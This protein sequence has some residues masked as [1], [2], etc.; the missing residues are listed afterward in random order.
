MIGCRADAPLSK[1]RLARL[2]VRATFKGLTIALLASTPA[3]ADGGDGGNGTGGAGGTGATGFNGSNGTAGIGSGGGGGGGANGGS[4]GVGG[5]AQGGAGGAAGKIGGDGSAGG[6]GGGGGGG[7][8]GDSGR[9]GANGGNGGNGSANGALV[10][11]GGGGGAGGYGAVINGD[12][13]AAVRFTGGNGGAGGVGVFLGGNNLFIQRGTVTGGNGGRGGSPGGLNGAGGEGVVGNSVRIVNSGTISGGL[14]GDGATRANAIRFT[15]GNNTLTLENGSTI[16]GN[17]AVTGSLDFRQPTDATLSNAITGGGTVIKSGVGKLTLTGASTYS[18]G[19]TVSAG[20]LAV[21]GSLAGNAVVDAG[22]TLMG[23]GTVAGNVGVAGSIAPGNSI[24]TLT[25]GGNYTQTGAYTVE[26]ASP[27]QSDRIVVGGTAALT[28]GT[29]V[30]QSATGNLARTTSYTILTATGGLGGTTYAGVTSNLASLSPTLSYTGNAVM[31]SLF[32]SAFSFQNGPLTPN[33][34]AVAAA[35][36]QA[37]PTASGDFNNVL[38]ALSNLGTAQLPAT[39]DAIGGQAYSGFASLQVQS[40]LLL[41]DSFQFQAGGSGAAG[42]SA[43]LPGKTYV[44]LKP[45]DCGDACDVEPLWG[46]WGGGLGAFGTIAGDYNGHGTTYNLGGFVAG[47]DRKFVPGLRAGVVAGFNAASLYAQG[48]PGYGSSNTL[49]FALYGDYQRDAF[50]LDALAGYGHS[51]NR[52]T[53]PIVIPG[54]PF[55]SAQGYTTANTF[56][57][58]LEAG[59]KLA[60]APSFGGVVTPFARLQ[61]STSTQA[62]FTETGADSLNLNV[63]QQTTQSLRTVLGAQLG[64]AIDAPWR[65]KLNVNLRLGW[66]HEF[67]DPSRPVT[68]SFAGAPAIGFTTFGAVAPRDGVLLGLGAATA[69]GEATSIYVRYDGDLAGTNTN[70]LLS[71]GLRYVW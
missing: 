49:Q 15:G 24:G 26:V 10:G 1:D 16:N 52:M 13:A 66:S 37:S 21:N 60:V 36:D 41:M 46:A 48:I 6:G 43:G 70:N 30:V 62:G 65:S 12:V 58:Q 5:G 4:G 25:V 39:L 57:G 69:I 47:L 67:A 38:N 18:G 31:L 7:I 71:A 42:D 23:G 14:S 19:T 29:V 9:R 17:I 53:R 3:W 59:Y 11:G 27:G 56:F 32:N 34:R 51:D 20:T 40:A 22:A 33:Q 63:A 68:A 50:Y 61:A 45:D 44:A 55:R 54:L 2:G 64:A 8:N 35:L 28:G